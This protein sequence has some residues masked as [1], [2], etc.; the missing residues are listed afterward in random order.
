MKRASLKDSY[1][2][3]SWTILNRAAELLAL[4][5]RL[6][7]YRQRRFVRHHCILQ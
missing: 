4:D 3:V 2:F 1:Q 5:K 6:P 7:T